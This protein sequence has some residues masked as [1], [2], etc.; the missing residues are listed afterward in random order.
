MHKYRSHF[1]GQEH[2]QVTLPSINYSA[3]QIS[4]DLIEHFFKRLGLEDSVN[5]VNLSVSCDLYS[6]LWKSDLFFRP[7]AFWAW[8]TSLHTLFKQDY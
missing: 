1:T 4:I 6:D 3:T 8:S 2:I 7:A 5:S